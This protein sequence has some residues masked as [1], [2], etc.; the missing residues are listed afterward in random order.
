MQVYHD[1]LNHVLQHGNKKEDRTGA[2][3]LSMFGYQLLFNLEEGLP[4]LATKKVHLKSINQSINQSF[5]S[6]F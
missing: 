6:C 1:L 3:T 4:L 2:G 5:T